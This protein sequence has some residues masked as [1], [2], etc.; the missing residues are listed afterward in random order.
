MITAAGA[1]RHPGAYIFCPGRSPAGRSTGCRSFI[2]SRKMEEEKDGG[3]K[4]F[5]KL[6]I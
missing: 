5:K 1:V 2:K 6:G 4:R 3:Y